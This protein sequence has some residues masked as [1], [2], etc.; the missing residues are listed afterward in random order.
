MPDPCH[1]HDGGV[2]TPEGCLDACPIISDGTVGSVDHHEEDAGMAN[3]V[4]LSVPR[5]VDDE[6]FDPDVTRHCERLGVP[7]PA[8]WGERRV[9]YRLPAGV[10]QAMLDVVTDHAATLA[11]PERGPLTRLLGGRLDGWAAKERAKLAGGALK[12]YAPS[13]DMR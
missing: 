12:V 5:W 7:D 8:S 6:C 10:A 11:A 9:I 13:A 4:T 2:E 3:E 1:H